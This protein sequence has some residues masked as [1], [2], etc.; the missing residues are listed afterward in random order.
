MQTNSDEQMKNWK[1]EI[2][3]NFGGSFN[4]SILQS[5]LSYVECKRLRHTWLNLLDLKC[6]FCEFRQN[7]EILKNTRLLRKYLVQPVE[8]SA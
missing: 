7:S 8:P 5:P 6:A 4:A 3:D 2:N 1:F